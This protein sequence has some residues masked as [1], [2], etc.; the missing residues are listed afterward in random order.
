MLCMESKKT[1]LRF[2][3]FSFIQEVEMIENVRALLKKTMDQAH[4]QLW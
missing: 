4:E 1:Q 2:I 3:Y